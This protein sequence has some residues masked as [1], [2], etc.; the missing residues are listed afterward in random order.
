MT[1]ITSDVHGEYDLFVKLLQKIGF[2]TND[3]LIV[4]GDIID[5]GRNSVKLLQFIKSTPNILCI[6]GN[7]E[8]QFLKY[9][10]A[11]TQTSPNNFD[12]V[13]DKLQNYFP[14]DGKLLDWDAVDWLENLPYYI[15]ENEF[16]CVHAGVPLDA[17]NR[18]NSLENTPIEKFVYDRQFKEPDVMPLTDKCVFFGHTPTSYISNEVKIIKYQKNHKQENAIKDYYKIHLDLGVWLH[19]VLGAF[20]VE[21]CNEYYVMKDE[22]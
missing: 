14:Y 5:K 17:N 20:C 4:C 19:G 12:E 6:I 10:W 7:H 1:Y 15:E 3:K 8:Y 21:T 9:Y 13:L 11:I 22:I 16:I 2:S 18:L